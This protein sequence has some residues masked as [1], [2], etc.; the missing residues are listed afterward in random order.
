MCY[1]KEY[2]NQ[3]RPV[4]ITKSPIKVIALTNWQILFEL[5]LSNKKFLLN[6][7]WISLCI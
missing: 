7:I 2:K 3:W 6:Q 4:A 5:G 1:F